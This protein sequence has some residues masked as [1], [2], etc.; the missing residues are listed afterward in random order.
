[1]VGLGPQEVPYDELE[2][3]D[4][5]KENI[6]VAIAA[7]LKTLRELDNKIDEIWVDDCGDVQVTSEALHLSD[8]KFDE[9]KSDNSKR[10]PVKF[11]VF[12]SQN[13]NMQNGW[14]RGALIA[15]GQNIVRR[16]AEMPANLMT[17]TIF[18][19]EAQK[20]AEG[21]DVNV[22]V[23][24]KEWAKSKGMGSFLSVTQGSDEPPMFLELHYNNYSESLSPLVYV[25]KGITFDS[26]GLSLKS[27]ADMDLMRADMTGAAHVLATIITLAALKAKVNVVGLIPLSENLI[28]GHATKPG[29]V[30]TAMNGK[31]IKV[32]NTDAEG[33]LILA[34]ALCYSAEF[35]PLA[36][37]DIA[38]L[39]GAMKMA[40]AS[41]ACG[42]WTTSQRL[43]DL[44]LSSSIVSGDR[45][46][47]MPLFKDYTKMVTE[48]PIADLNNISA[49]RGATSSI[50]AAFLKQF[51]TCSNWM[52]VD[53]ASV[54][55]SRK[56][57]GYISR[58]MSGRPFRTMLHFIEKFFEN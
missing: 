49:G 54:M 25:G 16:L 7:A 8:Y 14:E 12:S 11:S 33:R 10:K 22:I 23:R 37:V 31:T 5:K 57:T 6:R 41:S 24:D 26:G 36:V 52:H 32:D 28:N 45:V 19:Q 48:D 50:A 51:V 1:V 27:S 21:T 34:D 2:Q 58:G 55:H 20:L 53:M 3:M 56:D 13:Q 15:Q 40:L 38:T 35:E 39:T 4:E 47:R 9:I 42:V 44:I 17:P 30:V 29:D 18:V 46:W 43:W